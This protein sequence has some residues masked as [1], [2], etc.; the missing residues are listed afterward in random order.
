MIYSRRFVIYSMQLVGATNG[1]IRRPLVFKGVLQG[2]V[3]SVLAMAALF[4]LMYG[5]NTRVAVLFGM[6]DLHAIMWIFAGILVAG[7]LL[8]MVCTH[9]SVNRFLRMSLD[10]LYY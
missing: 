6:E 3:A 10:K 7:I 4:A 2:V 8:C 1:F 9:V 5:V